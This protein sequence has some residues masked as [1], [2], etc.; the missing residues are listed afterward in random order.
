MNQ[1]NTTE[2][3]EPEVHLSI[4]F[5]MDGSGSMEKMGSE[6]LNGLNKLITKQKETGAFRFTLVVFDDEIKTV[7]ND[8]E[9]EEVPTLTSE[10]YKPEGMTALF[11]ARGDSITAQKNIKIENV[12]VVIL[13]DGEENASKRYSRSQIKELTTEMQ[14]IHK[15]AFMYLGANQDSFLVSQSLGINISQDYTY[16]ELG[17]NKIFRDISNE[18]S[19]CVSGE[20][21]V[22]NFKPKLV[23]VSKNIDIVEEFE[24]IP[25]D[26]CCIRRS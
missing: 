16:T 12:L 3:S 11:D 9:G 6:P 17:C 1:N 26:D 5:I 2:L 4:L 7:I 10:H 20:N 25:D 22:N 15:W 13:T 23:G 19:R 24:I 21:P 14:N 8:M 18:I